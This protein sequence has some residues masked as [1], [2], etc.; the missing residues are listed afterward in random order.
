MRRS[1]TARAGWQLAWLTAAAGCATNPNQ[2]AE[3]DRAIPGVT[4]NAPC[5]DDRCSE[6]LMC[7]Y[8][9]A[10]TARGSRCVLEPGRCRDEWDCGR[11]VQRCRRFGTQLGVCQDSGL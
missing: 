7:R 10:G 2:R 3:P 5:V 8:D 11:S 9:Y 1:R 4:V 6:G